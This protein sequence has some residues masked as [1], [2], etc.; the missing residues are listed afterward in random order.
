[1]R[2]R[3]VILLAL[4]TVLCCT[5]GCKR[6]ARVIPE[7]TMTRIYTEIY[8]ADQWFR[9]H[10]E[11]RAGADTTLVFD[12]I[13]RRYGYTFADYDKSVHY[14]LDKP[15]RYSKILTEA[16]DRLRLLGEQKEAAL[17]SASAREA[18]LDVF[19]RA[20]QPHDFSDDSLRWAVPGV[21]WPRH[22]APLAVRELLGFAS[23]SVA[24][25]DSLAVDSLAV[26]SLAVVADSLAAR[27][28]TLLPRPV[29]S[30]K[31]LNPRVPDAP[32]EEPRPRRIRDGAGIKLQEMK[33]TIKK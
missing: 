13:F 30:L 6:R 23:D 26:D 12:P 2:V 15:D 22:E 8:L 25:V 9:D 1:M 27:A 18:R 24:V 5:V 14:Y 7:R 21:L 10:P 31:P 33:E 32:R 17:D 19:R 20:Y 29:D 16:S 4:L 3:P 11:A 28:D